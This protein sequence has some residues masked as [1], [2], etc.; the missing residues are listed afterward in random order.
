MTVFSF[1]IYKWPILL[2]LSRH[3]YSM[4]S[5]QN[6]V[7]DTS[8]ALTDLAGAI[9]TFKWMPKCFNILLLSRACVTTLARG[10]RWDRE[11]AIKPQAWLEDDGIVLQKNGEMLKSSTSHSQA[12]TARVMPLLRTRVCVR[13]CVWP[14]WGQNM[15][16]S[17]SSAGLDHSM[18]DSIRRITC[19]FSLALSWRLMHVCLMEIMFAIPKRRLMVAYTPLWTN[20]IMLSIYITVFF[21]IFLFYGA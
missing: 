3:T 8:P 16:G 10:W 13:V 5:L 15:H 21:Y 6:A 14:Q 17:V 1:S 12:R 11:L 19:Y 2:M 4:T 7:W 9:G 20:I 18:T